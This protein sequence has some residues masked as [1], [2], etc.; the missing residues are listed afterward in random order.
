VSDGD[1]TVAG[2]LVNGRV[3]TRQEMRLQARFGLW[4]QAQ[5]RNV[6]RRPVVVPSSGAQ[7][8]PDLFDA[9]T[10]MVVEAKK[11]AAREYVRG[12][13]GQVLDYQNLLRLDGVEGVQAAILLPGAP[14]EDLM[15]LCHRLGIDVFVPDGDAFHTL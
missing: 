8:F 14:D 12:A 10:S 1:Y 5:G 6:L 15:V 2:A 4:L 9:S 3:V 7:V 13:I 11:S